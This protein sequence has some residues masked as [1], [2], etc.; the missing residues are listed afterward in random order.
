MLLD[1][2]TYPDE[3]LR[4]KCAPV[5][6]VTP[7]LR[8]LVDSMFETMYA[9]PG[10]GLAAPQVAQWIRLVVIDTASPEEEKK[11]KVLINPQLVCSGEQIR[12]KNE[13]CL[14]VPLGFR[15]DVNR[16][17][18]VHLTYRDL[19]WNLIE[20]DLTDFPAIVVQ[21]ETDHLDG[22]L[23]IDHISRL[24]RSLYDSKVRK[25]L[26]VNKAHA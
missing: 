13:G 20:E 4:T 10:V 19:D 2:V 15:A 16:Y 18:N 22:I 7:E 5:E 21:H 26:R 1:I 12:S 25:W 6:S 3:R 9:A 23:F 8:T 14:S 11:P 17:S 24:R